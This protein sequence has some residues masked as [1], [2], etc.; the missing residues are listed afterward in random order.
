MQA[1]YRRRK[2]L[3]RGWRFACQCDRCVREASRQSQ[4]KHVV[5]AEARA[6][7]ASVSGRIV[8]V[9]S[10]AYWRFRTEVLE[11]LLVVPKLKKSRERRRAAAVVVPSSMSW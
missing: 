7:A 2:E 10:L 9:L 5:Q 4:S 8:P 3:A 11:P 6:E 1:R